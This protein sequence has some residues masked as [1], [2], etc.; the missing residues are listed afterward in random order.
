MPLFINLFVFSMEQKRRCYTYTVTASVSI[1][2]HTVK[3]GYMRS[4]AFVFHGKK[5]M[6]ELYFLSD[7]FI[8]TLCLYLCQ[9]SLWKD[10]I[11][12]YLLEK[13]IKEPSQPRLPG[14]PP[15]PAD[16]D[17][18]PVDPPCRSRRSAPQL[19]PRGLA[20]HVSLSA[21][22]LKS[23]GRAFVYSRRYYYYS[24]ILFEIL[25]GSFHP[26][27]KILL[28]FTHPHVN[29]YDFISSAKHKRRTLLTE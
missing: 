20:P 26:I 22:T 16:Q 14:P 5:W 23:T 28:S 25:K 4:S 24:F 6:T 19:V 11:D 27:N 1:F 8:Y 9:N 18:Q 7:L 10:I 3:V 2:F 15:P 21:G 29:L 12:E 13:T 17:I